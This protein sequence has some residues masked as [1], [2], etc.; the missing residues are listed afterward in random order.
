M[1][2]VFRAD[3][4][5]VGFAQLSDVALAMNGQEGT[6]PTPTLGSPAA[7]VTGLAS[8]ADALRFSW[9]FLSLVLAASARLLG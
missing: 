1:Y 9:L 8:S 7:T 4:P 6:P 5:S 3:P 2:S